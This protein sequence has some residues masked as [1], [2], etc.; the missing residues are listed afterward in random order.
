[1]G[2]WHLKH[3]KL[4]LASTASSVHY[5]CLTAVQTTIRALGLTDVVS[6]SVVVK[7]LPLQRVQRSDSL[8]APIIL[9]T[10][11]RPVNPDTGSNVQ[12]DIIHSVLVSFL[13]DDNQEKTLAAN[14]SKYLLWLERVRKAFNRKRLSGVATVY[15]CVVRPFD[16]VSYP[17][18]LQNWWASSL[19]LQFTSRETR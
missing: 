16:P 8:T 10:P 4:G 18:W 15:T 3:W 1:M 2:H 7:K 17:H 13:D 19:L 5:N 6:A 9:I 12:D 14:M 11:G